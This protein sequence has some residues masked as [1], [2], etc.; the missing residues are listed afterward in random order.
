MM[1]EEAKVYCDQCSVRQECF[2]F[3]KKNNIR[4]GVW[5]GIDFFIS[6]NG[7]IRASVPD[8]ID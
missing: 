6:S 5:G 2:T 8:S 7:T 1:V 3:A 4:H